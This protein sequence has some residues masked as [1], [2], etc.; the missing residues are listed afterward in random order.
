[1]ISLIAKNMNK[2]IALTFGL[3]LAASASL[4]AQ[5]TNNGAVISGKGNIVL[6]SSMDISNQGDMVIQGELNLKGK[7][8]ISSASELLVDQLQVSDR[9]Q[10]AGN[11]TVNQQVDFGQQGLLKVEEGKAITFGP[12]ANYTNY[13]HGKGIQGTAKKVEA[14]GFVFPLGTDLE[15]FP[16]AVKEK[17]ALV[18][19]RII[20]QIS[21]EIGD[22]SE[23][24][25]EQPNRVVI[26]VNA[27]DEM[28]ANK[29]KLQFDEQKE[30]VVLAN[31]VWKEASKVTAATS[32]VVTKA[33]AYNRT[34][35]L[36]TSESKWVQV[37]PNPSNGEVNIYFSEKEAN[38]NVNFRIY[39]MEGKELK[40]IEKQG[41][42]IMDQKMVLDNL[43]T[44]SYMLQFES[45]TG[46]KAN[47]KHKIVR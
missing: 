14:E 6:S 4:L 15:A 3:C 9:T 33:M 43:G 1:M 36:E 28:Q 32:H 23:G 7:R 38:A 16:M 21:T 34:S 39:D 29:L 35:A 26:K 46:K 45:A 12:E 30:E 24:G 37:F 18:E 47:L 11:L 20:P 5:I 13:T 44:G 27:S 22:F 31:G 8:K 10:V 25:L 40:T 17:Q 42:A 2:N 19:A 41:Q